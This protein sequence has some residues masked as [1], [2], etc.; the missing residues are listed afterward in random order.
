MESIRIPNKLISIIKLC[1]HSEVSVI[2]C[3]QTPENFTITNGSRE[4]TTHIRTQVF[5]MRELQ[6]I[7]ENGHEGEQNQIYALEQQFFEGYS[8]SKT[9][10][11]TAKILSVTRF[12]YLGANITSE[13][14]TSEEIRTRMQSG[15][16]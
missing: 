9:S 10:Q 13:N 6:M 7:L 15:N 3:N 5:T 12:N 8:R 16:R 2:V 1:I 14:D 4:M 11:W